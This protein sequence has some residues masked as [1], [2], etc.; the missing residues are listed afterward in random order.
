METI[1][2]NNIFNSVL[3]RYSTMRGKYEVDEIADKIIQKIMM[4]QVQFL[5]M[6]TRD[7]EE[8]LDSMSTISIQKRHTIKIF[9]L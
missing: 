7:L 3:H 1:Y 9:H 4:N 6:L 2:R 8:V 5:F